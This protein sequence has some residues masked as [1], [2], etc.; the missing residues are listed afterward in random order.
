MSNDRVMIDPHANWLNALITQDPLSPT[1][2]PAPQGLQ[3]SIAT[4][5]TE[6]LLSNGRKWR[7]AKQRHFPGPLVGIITPTLPTLPGSD[8]KIPVAYSRLI[9]HE[10]PENETG[11]GPSWSHA[12]IIHPQ[13]SEAVGSRQYA[14]ESQCSRCEGSEVVPE[15][16][17]LQNE[18]RRLVE[19][20]HPSLF[21]PSLCRS[22][23]INRREG[24]RM[25]GSIGFHGGLP[26]ATIVW[27][28]VDPERD[29]GR[30]QGLPTRRWVYF[31]HLDLKNIMERKYNW[32]SMCP[33]C[34]ERHWR[35][36]VVPS[37]PPIVEG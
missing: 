20:G 11:E 22:C 34:F 1:R 13:L 16:I 21:D 24:A 7:C 12:Q 25:D 5:R 15:L 31:G 8:P 3:G 9:L 36:V 14:W 2:M 28:E 18:S 26:M 30:E 19:A 32:S 17:E 35:G 29:F 23:R 6:E 4:C 37:R 27:V 33:P 10:L